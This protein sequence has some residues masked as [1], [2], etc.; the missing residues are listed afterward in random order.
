M[1]KMEEKNYR[2]SRGEREEL[3]SGEFY[4]ALQQLPS[5]EELEKIERGSIA[6]DIFPEL[7]RNNPW[8]EID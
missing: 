6:Y 8:S 4:R 5:F 2:H 1:N 7:K 3:R